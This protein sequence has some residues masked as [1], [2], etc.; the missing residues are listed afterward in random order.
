M[1]KIEA[2]NFYNNILLAAEK[3]VMPIDRPSKV[4]ITLNYE[5][6]KLYRT[7]DMYSQFKDKSKSKK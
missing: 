1:D 6:F 4:R 5:E 3:V 7:G 2:Y